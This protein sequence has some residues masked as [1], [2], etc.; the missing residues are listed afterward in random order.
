M[1]KGTWVTSSGIT[2]AYEVYQSAPD[3]IYTV[4]S[5]PK[6]G[7]F[8]R[9]FN[10]Q[11]G[12][13]KGNRGIR[14]LEGTELFYLKRYP[15]LFKDIKLQG[16][17]SRL[18]FGGKQKIDGK[19]VYVLRGLTPD[20]K[21]EQLYFD[22]QTGLLLRRITNTP[23]MVGLIPEQVDYEDYRDVD[24]LKMPFSIRISSI[25]PFYSSTRKFTEVKLNGPIDETKFNKPAP[26]ASPKP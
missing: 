22:S 7:V 26:Q 11:S 5:T 21:G 4:L 16:Q 3:K 20:N 19:E 2:F 8:E 15:D 10:G 24:G 17:F 6:Q 12:W 18:T 13:E 23:T 25:D 9:G 14:D 1:M